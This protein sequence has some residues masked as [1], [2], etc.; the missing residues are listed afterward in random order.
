M[1]NNIFESNRVLRCVDKAIKQGERLF[2]VSGNYVEDQFFFDFNIGTLKVDELIKRYSEYSCMD[3]RLLWI[4]GDQIIQE[5]SELKPQV[6]TTKGIDV[7]P[8]DTAQSTD[9]SSNSASIINTIKKLHHTA[10]Q[11]TDDKFALL[12]NDFDWLAKFYD[13][14][15]EKTS[16]YF[17]EIKKL[18][19]LNNCFVFLI[20]KNTSKF[21][22]FNY[23][24]DDKNV[25]IIGKPD[26]D[27]L[28]SAFLWR[29]LSKYA[30]KRIIDFKPLYTTISALSS[31][32]ISVDQLFNIM[33]TNITDVLDQIDEN[34]FKEAISVPIEENVKDEDVIIS[35]ETKE[36]IKG[37]LAG[38][39]DRN[40]KEFKK[41]FILTGPPGTGKTHIARMIA[42]ENQCYFKSVKLSDVKGQYVGESAQKVKLLFAEARANA[43]SILF[44][45]EIDTVLP[46]R[47][48]SSQN[49]DSFTKDIVNEFLVNIDGAGTQKDRIFVIG[50][51]N[52]PN[53][54]DGAITSRLNDVIEIGLPKKDEIRRIFK[55]HIPDFDQFGDWV[56]KFLDRTDGFSGRD[57]KNFCGSLKESDGEK[58]LKSNEVESHF[59]AVLKRT[60]MQLI[61]E[62]GSNKK[63]LEVVEYDPFKA[64]GF[65]N[66][67][68]YNA[69][70]EKIKEHI[71]LIFLPPHLKKLGKELKLESKGILFYGPPGNGKTMFAGAIAGEYKMHLIKVLSK[72]IISSSAEV[73]NINLELVFDSAA[74]LSTIT[75]NESATKGVV[76]FF[77]EFDAIA[78][79]NSNSIVRGTLLDCL[80]R[81]RS[82]ENLIIVAATNFYDRLDEASI[83][84]GR[85]DEHIPIGN[86][87]QDDY[88]K[89]LDRMIDE[90][91]NLLDMSFKT[92]DLNSELEDI[93]KEQQ[94][95]DRNSLS[96]ADIKNFF[97]NEV[98]SEF[99]KKNTF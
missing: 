68:G 79:N 54:L 93:R 52:R 43:P 9:T 4:N 36:Q 50:A 86:P 40:C 64:T 16:E 30:G 73:T 51:T 18:K 82:I 84:K 3:N 88:P 70:K 8:P 65:D 32:G 34:L 46:A 56:D 85:F 2:I 26:T 58:K 44:V 90:K 7:P 81:Y 87:N 77:D 45:D 5:P 97:T 63:S 39:L 55:I 47:N 67:I 23:N 57:I 72:D 62:L 28:F 69:E 71:R 48:S 19:Q 6:T 59:Y 78:S 10:K 83:R 15:S 13:K 33:E 1:N 80:T 99:F 75:S 25:T 37:I 89:I 49:S 17:C 29:Y 66:I 12:I 20:Q 91:K 96:F 76:L 41:G 60:E 27:E 94:S 98:R 31:N 22:E 53:V 21:P 14:D 95:E 38:F 24:I 35:R 74:K 61:K 92:S 42:N 11:N